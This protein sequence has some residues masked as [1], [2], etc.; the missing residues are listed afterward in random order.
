MKITTREMTLGWMA[1]VVILLT[2]SFLFCAPKITVWKEVSNKRKAVAARI[3]LAEHLT[4]QR[5]QWNKKL[6]D[7]AQK[8]TKYPP[9]QDVVADYLRILEDVAKKN[10][11]TLSQRQ[12]QREKKH[13]DL[14][15]LA[16]DCPWDADLEALVRFLFD[17]EQQKV[18]MDIDDLNVSLVA[19]GKGKLKGKFAL[20][21]LY[22]R[23]GAPAAEQK[24]E[25]RPSG[26][27]EKIIGN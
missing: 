27:K 18:T 2:L 22:T 26:K 17:L 5:E 9:D 1:G 15:E 25:F 6:Q 3:E 24:K 20:I 13:N 19:G 14:Y 11:I 8:L 23:T 21:C 12:P 16:I 4:A 7:V 10:G